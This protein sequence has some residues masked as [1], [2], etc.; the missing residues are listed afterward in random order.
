VLDLCCGTGRTSSALIAR[1]FCVTALDGS[2]E[3]LDFARRNAPAAEFVLADAREFSFENRFDLVLSI[4]ESLNHILDVDDLL[5][6]FRNVSRS[7]C[8]GGLCLFDLNGEPAFER[9]WN[10]HHAIVEEDNVCICR[11]QYDTAG[12]LG[13]VAITMC[14]HDPEWT[15]WDATLTQRYHPPEKVCQ[16]L[17]SAGLTLVARWDATNDLAVPEQI[18]LSR[19]FYLCQATRVDD[20]PAQQ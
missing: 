18:G 16:L 14:R 7:L 4:F 8:P 2:S 20:V 5:P 13:T 12:R 19:S 10:S 3:M 1:G 11:S 9:Y 6:V 17:H 15:R